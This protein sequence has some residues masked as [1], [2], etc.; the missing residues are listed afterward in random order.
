LGPDSLQ[1]TRIGGGAEHVALIE[2]DH[3]WKL[4]SQAIGSARAGH[5][6]VLLLEGPSGIGKSGLVAV[7]AALAQES[8]ARL[9]R[10]GG[11]RREADL[12]FGVVLQLFEPAHGGSL[13]KADPQDAPTSEPSFGQLH[14][15][16]RMCVDMCETSAL[17]LVV[18]DVDLADA[19]SMRFL[20]YLTER[21]SELPLAVVLAAGAVAPRRRS[22]LLVD[23]ARHRSTMRCPLEP[24]TAVGTARWVTKRWLSGAADQAAVEIH[25]ASGGN[26]YLVDALV[27]AL[28]TAGGE[29]P[30]G[31]VRGLVPPGVADWALARA[32]D[33]APAARAVLSAVAVLGA[34]C[35]LRHVSALS[36]VDPEEASDL[37]DGLIE[38]GLLTSDGRLSF[39]APV[40]ATA[41]VEAMPPGERAAANVRAARLLAADDEAPERVAGHLL[42]AARTGS[43]WAVDAL[44]MGAAMALSRAAPRD[45]VRYLRRALVEP[46][47]RAQRAHVVLELARAEA[48]AGEPQAAVRL[49]DVVEHLTDGPQRPRVALETGRALFALGRPHQALEAFERVLDVADPTDPELNGRLRAGHA[50]AEWLIA[51]PDGSA[52]NLSAEPDGNETAGDRALLALHAMEAAISGTSA[53]ARALAERALARGALLDEETSDGLTYH[54]A[55]VALTFAEDLQ[56]AEAALTAAVQDA[57]SRGSVLGFATASHARAMTI[58]MR[59]R[60][61]DAAGDARLALAVERHGWRVGLGGARVVLATVEIERGNLAKANRHL[62]LA[63][64]AM[65]ESDAF[66]LFLLP[67]RGRLHLLSGD[68]PSALEDFLACGELADRARVLNP[69]I[70]PWQSSAALASAVMGDWSEA[71]RLAEAELARARQFGAPGPVGRALRGLAAVS[72]PRSALEALEAAVETMAGSHAAL[73]RAGALVDFGAALRRSGRRRDAREPLLAG[74]DLAERCGAKVLADRALRETDASGA[75]PRRKALHGREA[76]TARESQVASLAADGLTNREIAETLVVTIKTVEWHLRHSYQKLGVSSRG[77]LREALGPSEAGS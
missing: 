77:Q 23:I 43:T 62:E 71:A 39:T 73:E 57:Q 9:L 37:A 21:V 7:I 16:Y 10:A 46:P 26:P 59:G 42:G 69:A 33:L 15:L 2:R 52:R 3:A 64:A 25:D 55:A 72:Q 14:A 32:D 30:V 45:A 18:D 41:V 76:L 8:G 24:L 4:A 5:G 50:T 63:E 49:D 40:V 27:G 56:M 13:P 70:A 60:L 54:L 36:G 67:V 31:A 48:M 38:V 53:R 47:G 20:L 66:R 12:P 74:L 35:E 68:A 11:R 44:C 1:G 29:P 6:S 22:S 65:G 75:R 51:L 28:E 58:L 34:G 61:P 19:A 17:A